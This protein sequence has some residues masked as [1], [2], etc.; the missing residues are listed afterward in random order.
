M[1]PSE[2][3]KTEILPSIPNN[4]GI[5]KY[6][7][8]EGTILYV[9]KAKDLRKR[10]SSYFVKTHDNGK[11]R[12]LVSKIANIEFTVVETEQDALLLENVIIKE[13]QPRYNILLKDDKT[14]PYICI[15]KEPFPRVFITRQLEND[16]AEYFG[17][18]ASVVQTR[19]I[20]ELVH[21]LFQLR[22]CALSLTA[23]NIAEAKFKVCLEF[24][25]GNCKGPCE[26]KQAEEEYAENIRQIR[27]ILKGNIAS[28]IKFL[29]DKMQEYAEAFDF[30]KAHI[31]KQKL[32]SLQ[33]YQSKSMVVNPNINDVD[34]FNIEENEKRAYISFFKVVNG[35]IIQTKV[36][37]LVKKLEETPEELLT[38]GITELRQQFNSNSTELILPFDPDY[39]DKS[40][41]ITVPLIGDKRK[42]LD[43]AKKNAFY[44][45]KQFEIKDRQR[46]R[47]EEQRFEV[48]NQLKKDLR[49]TEL[50]QH[51]ECFDNSNLGGS[52]PVA[53]MV[54]FKDGKPANKEYRHY[55]I[56]TVEGPND[57]ASM[58]EIVHRRY[59]R[60]LAEEKSL[61]Q[62]IVIDGG[63][64]QLSAAVESLKEVGIY[65]KVAVIGIAKKLEEIYV[66]NDPYPLHI[67]KRSPSLKLIQH[68]RNEAHRFAI[69]FHRQLRAKGTF[70]SGL[71]NIPGIGPKTTEKLLTQLK[72]IENIKKAPD[73]EL[74]KI[75]NS[76]Q[77]QALKVYFDVGEG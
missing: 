47:P 8:E 55:K 53:S 56:K 12:I 66:P 61:P 46:K 72:S 70:Q 65:D 67:D 3:I 36:V 21:Q 51:I 41:K 34:V 19:N 17:P 25:L 64:G 6:Y 31:I 35:S 69:T 30:E 76:K 58:T 39:P 33:H 23:K 20:V 29:K 50:P 68:I 28:V 52:Y 1:T 15:K 63:K 10:V 11:T 2:R 74:L 13:L 49:L 60:L 16:G 37:E 24:H 32:D 71:D 9:G 26:A 57:F 42:L 22:T 40:L 14:Y 54:V 45:R 44:Y 73:E 75:L 18:Y 38:F 4:P 7:D 62:L 43:L 59:K 48:L 27:K 5:Y 77:L